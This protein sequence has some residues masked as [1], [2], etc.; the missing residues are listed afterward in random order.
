MPVVLGTD[1]PVLESVP[2]PAGPAD[3]AVVAEPSSGCYIVYTLQG[4]P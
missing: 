4:G 1:I 3:V 2:S